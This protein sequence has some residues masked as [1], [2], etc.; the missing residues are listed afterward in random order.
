MKPPPGLQKDLLQCSR[1]TRQ[2]VL[3]L[4][5]TILAYEAMK[6]G[7][8]IRI[9]NLE[10]KNAALKMANKNLKMYVQWVNS[11]CR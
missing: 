7:V 4:V 6:E 2:Y 10:T 3:S 5:D 9:A 1:E 8:A 11:S